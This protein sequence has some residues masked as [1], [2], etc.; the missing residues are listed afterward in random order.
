MI[1]FSGG[2][3]DMNN[4][5]EKQKACLAEQISSIHCLPIYACFSH[6]NFSQI[7][8]SFQ[9]TNRPKDDDKKNQIGQQT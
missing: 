2:E 6:R 4:I 5:W 9:I 1:G 3:T 7:R 8:Y